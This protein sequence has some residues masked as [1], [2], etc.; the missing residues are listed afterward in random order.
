MPSDIAVHW[1]WI[2]QHFRV[3]ILCSLAGVATQI[4]VN[5]IATCSNILMDVGDG[6]LRDLI[7]LPRTLYDNI[8][9][10]LISHGH[11][12]H[13]GSIFSLLAFFRMLNR[14]KRLS[15][16]SPPKVTELQGLVRTFHESYEDSTPFEYDIIEIDS[17]QSVLD[18]IIQSFPVQHRGSLIGG[19]EL[20]KIPAIGFIIR[21]NDETIVYT[22]D[23]GYFESLKSHITGA[24]LAIIEGTHE[25]EPSSYHLSVSQAKELGKLAK[26]H[27]IIHRIPEILD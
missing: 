21:K 27:L 13:V 25:G 18:I 2:G 9:T 8:D 5:D 10:I 12:D 17:E 15:I 19:D 23:T 24:D 14:K 20:P 11:F 7:S 1:D 26:N 16:I 6:I 4:L 22:G 3:K